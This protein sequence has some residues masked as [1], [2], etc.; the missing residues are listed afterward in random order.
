MTKRLKIKKFR[1]GGKLLRFKD[2]LAQGKDKSQFQR[3]CR[4][5]T[6]KYAIPYEIEYRDALPKTLFGKVAYT[7][8]EKKRLK[9][10]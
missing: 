9:V 6:A 7:L 3:A 4:R 8:L 10:C 2:F 5:N 1:T